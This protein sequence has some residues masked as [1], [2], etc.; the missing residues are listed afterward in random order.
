MLVDKLC[1]SSVIL[2][3]TSL[4]ENN[5]VDIS[6]ALFTF[7]QEQIVCNKTCEVKV[8]FHDNFRHVLHPTTHLFD[9]VC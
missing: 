9:H 4:Y 7:S 2:F 5:T 8:I 1:L 6:L 3:L